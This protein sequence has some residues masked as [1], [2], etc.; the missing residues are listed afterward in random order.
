MPGDLPGDLRVPLGAHATCAAGKRCALAGLY[1]ESV[2]EVGQAPAAVWTHD[3]EGKGATLTYARHDAVDL[4]GVVIAGAGEVKDS[5]GAGPPI[6]LR[7]WMAFR[8]A[9]GGVSLSASEPATRVVVAAVTSG[10]PIAQAAAEASSKKAASGAGSVRPP[11]GV[12]DLHGQPDLSW[13]G[14]AMHARI[15][16]E[17]EKVRASF[18]VLMASKDAAVAQHDHP[19]SWEI[20]VML[21]G[22]GTLKIA[23]APA[24]SELRP[25][26][27]A[28]G[29]VTAVPKATQHAWLPG[30]TRPL[31]ALQLYVPAGPEQ[32]FKALASAPQAPR[33]NP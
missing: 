8:A 23:T 5:E 20:L 6:A 19:A 15:G 13:G 22:Q 32:R 16:F 21:R 28:D 3:L 33:A 30:D 11:I 14:G 31:V 10:E 4:Y 9:G 1:P 27:L 24:S 12:V 25:V 7:P 26:A 2:R 18:G 17:G 29:T